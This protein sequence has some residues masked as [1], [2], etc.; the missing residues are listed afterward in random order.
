VKLNLFEQQQE[1][2]FNYQVNLVVIM[3]KQ[4]SAKKRRSSR[5]NTGGF[6]K[7]KCV[8]DNPI[9]V[10]PDAV[11]V[12]VIEE[13]EESL[14]TPIGDASLCSNVMEEDEMLPTP[15]GNPSL[16]SKK[17]QDSINTTVNETFDYGNEGTIFFNS[18][19]LVNML[20]DTSCC[21]DCFSDVAVE[22]LVN[23]KVGLAHFI[24]MKCKYCV[25]QKTYCS[26]KKVKN[27][28]KGQS[29]YEVN[30]VSI[31]AFRE[32]GVGYDGIKNFCGVMNM[33]HP[34]SKTAF[35]KLSKTV[36]I[37][38]V[39]VANESMR[40]AA[41]EVRKD[42]LHDAYNDDTFVDT[43]VSF[44]GTWQKR[45]HVSFNGVVT[46]MSLKGKCIDYEIKS[47]VCKSCQYWKK[48]EF[49]IPRGQYRMTY[50]LKKD[51]D[52]TVLMDQKWSDIGKRRRSKLRS[53]RKK[54]IVVAEA[55]EGEVYGKG[56]FH[57]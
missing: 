56:R 11:N 52:R 51:A 47:K 17:L 46:A 38:Y 22:F 53:I 4:I 37:N 16:S 57:V 20:K 27:C 33:P 28:K 36:H 48:R 26:S 40:Q 55:K 39:N 44:D 41:L 15:A 30:L 31:V 29:P 35:Q 6:S 2:Y 7:K 5:K 8:K 13:G 18:E 23:N 24:E 54:F 45:G 49:I 9:T 10:D 43:T 1:I 32:I 14:P 3:F 42:V 25:W 21:P 19:L 50:L 12:V 34:M